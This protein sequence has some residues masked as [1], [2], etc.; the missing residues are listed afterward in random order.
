MRTDEKR[1]AAMTLLG[2][3]SRPSERAAR[4]HAMKNCLSIIYAICCIAEDE[5][6]GQPDAG[7]MLGRMAR[8]HAAARRVNELLE[9]DLREGPRPAPAGAG[10]TL[11]A[12]AATVRARLL[13]QAAAAGVRL[14]VTAGRGVVRGD[15]GELTEALQNIVK[16]AIEASP[17]DTDVTVTMTKKADGHHWTVR[18][19]GRGMARAQIAQLGQRRGSRRP[20]GSGIG[21]GMARDAIERHGGVIRVES[22]IGAG[23]QVSVWLPRAPAA[24]RRPLAALAA[25]AE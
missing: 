24:R 3:Y 1:A 11:G 17:S 22:V 12:I 15:S 16:N 25:A 21:L 14:A 8:V 4:A 19:S 2:A 23:T 6:S 10:A 7:P 18:D 9:A 5:L 13:D 20:G